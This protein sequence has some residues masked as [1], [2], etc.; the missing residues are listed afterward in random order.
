M[1][2]QPDDNV[3]HGADAFAWPP[4]FTLDQERILKLLTGDRF[5]SN[6]SA[7]L[8]EV[9][10]N[11]I[12]AIHRR[13]HFNQA[14]VPRIEV[15]FDRDSKSMSVSD[16]G[17]GMS[18]DAVNQLFTRVGASASNLHSGNG[19]VGEFGIGVV[20]YFMASDSFDLQT[21]DGTSEPIGLRFEAGMLV[22]VPALLLP[23]T[24]CERGTTIVL[25]LRD[26][27]TFELLLNK[28]PYWC[29][30]VQGLTAV[31]RPE[32]ALVPQGHTYTPESVLDQP[33]PDWVERAH[34]VP[35][36]FFNAWTPM[37]GSSTIS[38]LYR[39]VFVQEFTVPGVWGIEGSIDVNPTYF[40]PRLNREGFVGSEFQTEVDALLRQSHPDILV[41]MAETVSSQIAA[42][43]LDAWN[44][45]RW[46]TLWLSIPRE[47]DYKR[48]A[49]LWDKTFRAVPA[50][51]IAAGDNWKPLCLD[52]LVVL[53]DEVYVA[54][55]KS[56]RTSDLVKGALRLL[57]H[58][59]RQVIRGLQRDR[60]W[61]RGASNSF[62]TTAD[63]IAAVFASELP[64]LL[65]VAAEAE[66]ILSAV[67]PEVT[68]YAG[69]PPVDLVR[70]G[71]DGP[72]I[73]RLSTR[74]I[75][76][77]DSEIGKEIV[78]EA[79]KHNSGRWSLI[80][81]TAR[82][83]HEHLPQ[84]AAALRDSPMEREEFGLVKRRFIRGLLS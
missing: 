69:V 35:V 3:P 44:E 61:L 1:T 36:T 50:F 6:A 13:R 47:A 67:H 57:R 2:S 76:N 82:K 53:G 42:G 66:R 17:D 24:R 18:K 5:Y 40:K 78:E 80:E 72:P 12:D 38:V 75:V 81:I 58:T 54:P 79:L 34:L 11:G 9:V 28:F 56:E 41:Q 37:S 55:H 48:P 77:I 52:E 32:G 14:L 8:R 84:V 46:A 45:H 62:A 49:K 21:W 4:A 73:L 22:G 39:G 10:L 64:P 20:S 31:V 15:C 43:R 51:E 29:R 83:S 23:A 71:L 16:N 27:S 65:S 30:D 63:L 19:P 26:Q 59:K 33:W 25:R 7:A 74:L 70:I 60:D 68:L